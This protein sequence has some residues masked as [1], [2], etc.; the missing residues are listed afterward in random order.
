MRPGLGF[1]ELNTFPEVIIESF[2]LVK[3][4]SFGIAFIKLNLCL[5]GGFLFRL[6]VGELFPFGMTFG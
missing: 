2:D 3:V 5:I 1:L 4:L 6:E